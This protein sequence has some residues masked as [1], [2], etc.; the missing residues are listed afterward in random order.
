[1]VLDSRS[2][3]DLRDG[4]LRISGP[5]RVLLLRLPEA[6]S[7][8]SEVLN[9]LSR[10]RGDGFDDISLHSHPD[11]MHAWASAI[12][13]ELGRS[14]EQEL[15]LCA[16]Q[17]LIGLCA[18]VANGAEENKEAGRALGLCF[19]GGQYGQRRALATISQALLTAVLNDESATSL[20]SH[21]RTVGPISCAIVRALGEMRERLESVMSGTGSERADIASPTRQLCSRREPPFQNQHVSA[22]WSG[23]SAGAIT[24]DELRSVSARVLSG[25]SDRLCALL[26][27]GIPRYLSQETWLQVAACAPVTSSAVDLC[28]TA[29]I[30]TPAATRASAHPR[31]Y[32][33]LR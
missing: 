23:M 24:V 8:A 22:T 3:L 13:A 29:R 17:E 30:R 33:E 4:V 25:V 20:L 31:A 10:R 12:E 16:A 28:E 15:D 18:I 26:E 2:Q 21:L 27:Q 6:S 11:P 14:D 19:G 9:Q 7:R 1:M 32:R 5:A